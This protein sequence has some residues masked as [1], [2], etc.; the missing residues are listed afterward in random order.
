ML[1][2]TFI[3]T[4][5]YFTLFQ[6]KSDIETDGLIQHSNKILKSEYLKKQKSTLS[7]FLLKVVY[8][9]NINLRDLIL[10]CI[11]IQY[12]YTLF[13]ETQAL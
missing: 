6:N 9:L 10:I 2:I 11:P 3:L 12:V 13:C 4:K 5:V 7:K 1:K 8:Q